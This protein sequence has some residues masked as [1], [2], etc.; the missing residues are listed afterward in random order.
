MPNQKNNDVKF[1]VL[2]MPPMNTNSVLVTMGQDTVIFDAW[3]RA[4]DWQNLLQQRNLNLRA[5]YATH[6]HPDHVSAASALAREMD[7][8]WFL[9]SNDN[10]Y[11]GNAWANS[12][13][14]MFGLPHIPN[15]YKQPRDLSGVKI[16]ILPGVEMRVIASPGHTPG[17]VMFYFP[18]YKILL[19]GDTL[20][21]D[22]VGR[23]D[24]TGGNGADLF[25]SIHNLYDM[26][27]DDD[28]F[29]V[30]GHGMETTIGWLKQNNPYFK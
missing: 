8:D 23:Y 19:I 15:D 3:G 2:H 10:F 18:E 1:E 20:F 22:N 4:A 24:M 7:V 16:E 30:H 5:I 25:K 21:Q 6:G 27:L 9:N 11:V 17:G 14:D 13:L 12:F 26:N 28:V 29:V